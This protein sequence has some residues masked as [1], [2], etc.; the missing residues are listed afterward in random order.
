MAD[1]P[2]FTVKTKAID[3]GAIAEILQRRTQIENQQN[4]Q[5]RD[6]YDQRNQ[7]I[8]QA[9]QA[10]Q[11]VASSM[12]SLAQKRNELKQQQDQMQGQQKLQNLIASPPP[13]APAP[14][15]SSAAIPGG[16]F[17]VQPSPEQNQTYQQQLAKRRSD[18]AAAL[19]QANP[20]AATIQQAQQMYQEAPKPVTPN[21]E[22]KDVLY[23]GQPKTVA[24]DSHTF[25]YYDPVTKEPL[26][27]DIKPHSAMSETAQIR[28]QALVD[29]QTEN[30]GK[31][32]NDLAVNSN[33]PA[34]ISAKRSLYAKSG[35][36]LI[37][38]AESQ[39][40]GVDKRQMAELQTEV[41]RVLT[42]SGVISDEQ[43][44]NLATTTAKS[45]VK[46]WQEW[47][48][49]EPTGIGQQAFVDRFKETL[50]RQSKFHSGELDK[51]KQKSMAKYTTF[52]KQA[53][54]EFYASLEQAGFDPVK[55]KKTRK[56]VPTVD[57]NPPEL[58]E[59][60]ASR[61]LGN[62]G[63]APLSSFEK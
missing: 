28:K 21:F 58:D 24:F 17:P 61:G 36:N 26:T 63:R 31:D 35:L 49:N 47:L 3:P 41:A 25:T 14:V 18:L 44:N 62:N 59:I 8:M 54:A 60:G 50:D 4:Q 45:K 7:R 43:L 52:E 20:Q 16:A 2:D 22:S 42:G 29:K 9:V 6:N 38:Q 27:G 56:L 48:L 37:K 57:M 32:L 15:A 30:M 40:G 23:N 51:Y 33:S 53:P 12:M 1:Q 19:L 55:Y 34:G 5:A 10:G 11:Q 46:N 13:E 39:P